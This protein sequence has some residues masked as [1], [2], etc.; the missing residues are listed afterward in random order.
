MSKAWKNLE[1]TAAKA[2]GGTRNTR[3]GDFGKS[4]PDVE[5]SLFSIEC[6]YR[7]SLP[8][9]LRQGLEQARAYDLKKPPLLVLKE[10][11]KHGAL[12]VLKLADFEDL[13]GKLHQPE[14]P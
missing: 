4:A 8:I 5:H 10:K 12:V 11:G 2:L 3:G 7:K 14:E 1:R 6:K 9:L 13:F